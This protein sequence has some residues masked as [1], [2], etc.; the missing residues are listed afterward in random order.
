M[1]SDKAYNIFGLIYAMFGKNAPLQNSPVFNALL[2]NIKDIPDECGRYIYEQAQELDY[3]PANMT[4]F[5][6]K[7]FDMLK[8]NNGGDSGEICQDCGGTGGTTFFRFADGKWWE[9]FAPCPTCTF[10]P[11]RSYK[12]VRPKCYTKAQLIQMARTDETISLMP[13]SYGGN[14]AKYR[15]DS[16]MDDLPRNPEH[17]NWLNGFRERFRQ[18]RALARAREDAERG[19][20][21]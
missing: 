4:K 18:G 21:E 19:K 1:C 8:A 20:E 17:D 15:L 7:S 9:C 11:D 10:I 2:D 13:P 12:S 5:F 3:L 16:G 6:R 14:T